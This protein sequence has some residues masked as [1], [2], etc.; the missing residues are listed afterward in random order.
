MYS[1]LS[2][3]AS[4]FGTGDGGGEALDVVAVRRGDWVAS[5]PW[6]VYVGSSSSS[7]GREVRVFVNSR[8]TGVRMRV[9]SAGVA[10]FERRPTAATRTSSVSPST[11]STP[12]GSVVKSKRT[13]SFSEGFLEPEG[14]PADEPLSQG[15]GVAEEAPDSSTPVRRVR[16]YDNISSP[17]TVESSS[18][19]T[20]EWGEVPMA[21][22][23]PPQQRGVHPLHRPADSF[24][25]P[26]LSRAR[27]QAEV[28]EGRDDLRDASP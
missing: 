1:A 26:E 5:S 22:L 13:R 9:G 20:W 11:S 4:V 19:W 15:V 10:Y 17:R 12:Q 16:S 23:E 27:R 24:A 18:E 25:K 7:R 2:W 21:A 3:A 28:V 6:H 14:A 8:D